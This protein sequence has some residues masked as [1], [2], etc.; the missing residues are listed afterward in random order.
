MN[1]KNMFR[2]TM[3]AA[4]AL[5]VGVSLTACG[6]ANEFEDANTDNL[7][8]VKNYTDSL[9]IPHPETL[10]NTNWQRT[11]G[12]KTNAFGEDIQGFVERVSFVSEDSVAVKMSQGATTGTWV[13]ESNTD[14]LPYYE[15]TYS[16]NTGKV[17]ILKRVQDDK[18]KV[19]KTAI[20][21]GVAVS[22]EQEVLTVLHFGD[23]PIQSYLVKQ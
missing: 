18:G 11:S 5:F 15:Y 21:T 3:M 4:M 6:D 12:L 8:W 7:S 1:M 2:K 20:F 14:A 10:A 23:T 19:S 9:N 22:G 16:S 17:E 13:D